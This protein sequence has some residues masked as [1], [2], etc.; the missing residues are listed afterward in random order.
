MKIIKK[1]MSLFALL[2][3]SSCTGY[4]VRQVQNPFSHFGIR[5]ISVP[6]F[7]N[8]SIVPN[9][10]SIFTKEIHLLLSR[11]SGL[12]VYSGLRKDTDA[13]LLGVVSSPQRMTDVF[14]QSEKKLIS[15]DLLTGRKPFYVS[16]ST[17]YNLNL[18]IVLLKR[19]DTRLIKFIQ[20]PLGDYVKKGPQIVLDESFPLSSTFTRAVSGQGSIGHEGRRVNFTKSKAWFR[21]TLKELAKSASD[22][23]RKEVLNAF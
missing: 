10:S 1:M 5:S 23:M 3:F 12:K 6:M 22:K 17:L 16:S 9:V 18:R 2:N 11:Y 13:V 20:G 14:G 15:E 8:K 4:H 19:P 7:A 21:I